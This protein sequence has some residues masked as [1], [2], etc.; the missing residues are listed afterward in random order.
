M[1]IEIA[2]KISCSDATIYYQL[3]QK[4]KLLETGEF[5]HLTIIAKICEPS[6][7]HISKS[8]K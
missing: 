1:R 7:I 8:T 2:F 5:D 6:L 3:F 4:L